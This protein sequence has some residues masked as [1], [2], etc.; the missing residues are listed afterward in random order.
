MDLSQQ[1]GEIDFTQFCIVYTAEGILNISNDSSHSL[2]SKSG[3]V[4]TKKNSDG[5]IHNILR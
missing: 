4:A 5:K 3:V 1:V 2:K